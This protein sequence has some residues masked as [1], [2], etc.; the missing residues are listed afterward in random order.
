[1]KQLDQLMEP[2]AL[3]FGEARE[4]CPHYTGIK[5]DD[6]S[7]QCSH[8]HNRAWGSWCAMDQCPLLRD[9]ARAQNLGWG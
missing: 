4:L 2:V 1:M 8:Q 3:A 5:E 9:S 6:D 7:R